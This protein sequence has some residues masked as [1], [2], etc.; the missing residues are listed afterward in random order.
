[1][2]SVLLICRFYIHGF[3]LYGSK[4][5]LELSECSKMQNLNLHQRTLYL[6]FTCI[7]N[8]LHN[9][10]IVLHCKQSRDDSKYKG[11]CAYRRGNQPP[12]HPNDCSIVYT[13]SLCIH[14][15]LRSLPLFGEPKMNTW[16]LIYFKI[17]TSIILHKCPEVRFLD[18]MVVYFNFCRA[19]IL[20]YIATVP[21]YIPTSDIQVPN[22]FLNLC[23][24]MSFIIIFT[25]VMLI[26]VRWNLSS[27]FISIFLMFG[28]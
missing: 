25:I 9:T 17:L 27:G 21:F 11:G 20:F 10:H 18:H 7:Y 3:N 22:F 23:K 6:P 2:Q 26:D 12:G 16:V 5:S 1:M 15:Q 28:D 13:F 8:Y 19:S 14:H 24:H 4:I